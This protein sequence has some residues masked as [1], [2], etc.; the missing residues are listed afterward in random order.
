MR[1]ETPGR[2]QVGKVSLEEKSPTKGRHLVKEVLEPLSPRLG[3]CETRDPQ[4]ELNPSRLQELPALE[5]TLDWLP[6][7][8]CITSQAPYRTS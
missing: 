3:V 6:S 7:L 1:E 8:P 4:P 2:P 5:I